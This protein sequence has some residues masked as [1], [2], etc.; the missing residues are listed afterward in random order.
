[1][2]SDFVHLHVHSEYSLLDGLGRT[3]HL[4][5]EAA[6]LGQ[7][8]LAL[9]DH[10]VMHGVIEFSRDCRAAGVKP[11]IGVEA[12]LTPHGRKMTGRAPNEDKLRHHLL[13]LAQNMTGYKNLLQLCSD[14]Q[15]EGYYYRPRIDADYLATHADG[16]ICTT[17]CMAAEIPWLLNGAEGRPPQEE[18]ALERLQWYLDVFGRDRFF[19]ELQE[20]DIPELTRIN[21]TLFD[22]SKK[23]NI[24][25]LVTNDVHY[26]T[27]EEAKPHDTLLCVQTSSLVKQPNR[28]RMSDNSYYL[29]SLEELKETFRPL[30]DLPE[31]AFTNTLKIAE[32]CEVDLEDSSYHLPDLPPG[33]MPEGY[34]YETFL[35]HLTDEGLKVRYG[36]RANDPDIQAQKEHELKIIHGMGFDVYYLIVWDLCQYARRRN[37]WWNVRGSGAGSIVAYATGIT[38]I[39]PLRHNLI[40]ERFLNPGRVSMPDFD[41][42]YPDDQREEMIR[43]TIDRYGD[44]RVAQIVSFGR[45][46]ARAAIRDVGRA[47]DVPLS[48]VDVLAK[49][50][51]AIPGKPATIDNTLDSEHEFFAP[52]LK[53]QYD[54]VDYVHE[55]V[56]SARSLEG[57]ARHASVHA[58]AVIITDKPL[59]EYVPVMRPQ[60]SVITKSVTQ[61]EFPVCESIGLLKVDFLGLSTLTIMR[62]AAELI[63]ERHGLEFTLENLPMDEPEAFEHLPDF[64]PPEKAFELLASG[65]VTGVFQVEGSGMRR[66]LTEM[67]PTKFEH[68]VAAISL[69]RPGPMEYIPTYI[70]RMHGE[71][72]VEYKHPK[73]EKILGDTYAIIVYQE[74][75][76]QIASELAGYAPGEADQIRKAVGKKIKDKID[77]HRAKFVDG[78][79]KNGIE[80]PVAEAIYG[81]IEFFARYGFNKCL[82]GD[83][84]VIDVGTGR[85]VKLEN[86]YNGSEKIGQV[87]ACDIDTLKINPH[88]VATVVDN[89]VKP[90][91]RLTTTL[92]RQIEAT[93]NHPFY[94]FDGWRQLQDLQVG[95]LI[96]VPRHLPV[97]GKAHWPDY[98]V[99]VL[100]HLLAEGNLCHPHSVYYYTQDQEN[101]NDYLRAVEQFE[102]VSCS[103]SLHKRTHSVYAR[104]IRRNQEPGVV[105]W[106][107]SLGI[108]GK[109]AGE[110]EIPAAA[111]ELKN[112]QIALLLSRLWIG[113]GHLSQQPDGYIQCYYATS[114]ERLAR[115]IQHLLLRLGIVSRLRTTTFPYKKGRIGYQ[116]HV[117]GGEHI[118]NFAYIVG[119]HFIS[120]WHRQMCDV[121]LAT[122]WDTARGTRDIIPIQVKEIVRTHKAVADITWQQI[123]NEAG[124]AQ[125]EFYPTSNTSKRGFRRETI[126]RLAEYF[127]SNELSRYAE[128]DIYWDE[129]NSIEYVGKKQ[130]YDLTV[131]ESH[132]F[133]ANDIL[134]HNSHAADY[135]L[136]TCQTAYLKAHYPIEYMTALLT[137]ERNNTDKIGM[138]VGECRTMGI[139]VLP[140]DI[141]R[142]F[143]EFVI[144]DREDQPPAIRFGL[145]AIKNVG[146]GPL[147]AILAARD[148][149]GDGP[150]HGGEDFTDID[151]FCSRVDLRQVGRRPL[152]CLIKVGALPAHFA[153]RHILLAIIDRMVNLS[154]STHKAAD[155]GQ[156]S[157]FDLGGFDAPR[158]GSILYPTPDVKESGQKEILSGE[159]ELTGAYLS[160]HPLQKH[161]AAIKASNATMLGELDETMHGQQVT[162]VGMI[163]FVRHHQTKKGD[164]M[165]FVEIED[166]QTSREIVVFP[167]TFAAHKDLLVNGNL[168]LV[169][170][171]VDAQNSN[172][173]KILA[174]TISNELTSYR[175]ADK[176]EPDSSQPLQYK[177]NGDAVQ[178]N[179]EKLA[180]TPGQYQP[181]QEQP[182]SLI[183]HLKVFIPRTGN[184]VQDKHRLK[185]VYELLVQNP[186]QDHF[187]LYIPSG[188]KTTR[189]D[190]PNHTTQDS[191]HLRQQL[192]QL[193]GVGTVRTE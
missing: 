13:L 161:L 98:E 27:A 20:H 193:L 97:S 38:L 76:I 158:T 101:L 108:W 168:I 80:K 69:F 49:Q 148:E 84:E 75:I 59:T 32:M 134:V 40:F 157:M 25:L 119:Q 52:E 128:N 109:K 123:R 45:M 71:E 60:G 181:V 107:K 102:N 126:T 70:K 81:D 115:Q 4:A 178:P 11:I 10:G 9:T 66:V 103:I 151:D 3:H 156:L 185:T 5:A 179:Q 39:D 36:D 30:A 12:Y 131:P 187:S 26:V 146:E 44:D 120:Q 37:I 56:D 127:D 15:L 55:L 82:P 114:S 31:S 189:V 145:G 141:N 53:V 67:K 68:I 90:V 86:L 172:N 73:L 24:D 165:A 50:I 23:H 169:Q 78:A 48:E 14:A 190:F 8:A 104:R 1:M 42:D 124:V 150:R 96:A 62:K 16:L 87:M 184:L 85:P 143:I 153:P 79:V 95:D 100:G 171:K 110:K 138:L 183:T 54:N 19:I 135:A 6:R 51:S 152:E 22:W 7:P 147:E 61:F 160:E 112:R 111:F 164:P 47:M 65:N 191:A 74:Q 43:Y 144:E 175:A 162:V 154:S 180:E 21:R 28:M 116:V 2:S 130:T 173:P 118:K 129:I 58:A 122:N 170:G 29:K 93:D 18:K 77:T 92:G 41:L 91:F 99:I 142:S 46:K 35:R 176:K 159:K 94:T 72:K 117:R 133:I 155:A 121:A 89:G 167:R 166:I 63:K 113:D 88:Q 57:V 186:G 132:N 33:T 137:V 149:A 83:V 188:Q 177:V 105:R 125:R 192:I 182:P 163:N 17:G 106:A 139:E 174:D 34:T 136:V 140:P 64:P